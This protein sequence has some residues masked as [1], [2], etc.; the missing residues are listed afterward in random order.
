MAL[1]RPGEKSCC[2]VK[3]EKKPARNYIGLFKR[4]K[5]SLEA[6]DSLL[7]NNGFFQLFLCLIN[8]SQ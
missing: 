4:N 5:I 7:K 2:N 8:K 3:G 6:N 1:K